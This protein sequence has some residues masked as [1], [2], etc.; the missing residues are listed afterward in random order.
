MADK[1]EIRRTIFEMFDN[2][3]SG[4]INSSEL[5]AAFEKL[6]GENIP[7]DVIEIIIT[8]FDSDKSG[9]LNFDEFCKLADKLDEM[10]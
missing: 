7:S 5:K 2:D 6:C 8:E 10:E 4:Q 9:N 3:K 1:M